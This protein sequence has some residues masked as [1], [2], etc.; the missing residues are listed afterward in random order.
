MA[1]ENSITEDYWNSISKK[2]KSDKKREYATIGLVVSDIHNGFTEM[3]CRG[4]M[5]QAAKDD[6]NL[7]VFPGRYL[8]REC[9]EFGES[10]Y[11]YQ[12]NSVYYYARKDNVDAL[13]IS[14]DSIGCFT[15]RERMKELMD[16]YEDIPVVLVASKMEGY[17]SI[18]YDNRQGI[19]DGLN[20]M[21]EKLG[22]KKICVM[23]G[24]ASNTD[25]TER[26]AVY[27]EVL[28]EHNIKVE[29]RQIVRGDMTHDCVS[30]FAKLLDDNPDMEGVFCINDEMALGLY[31]EMEKRHI[32]PG[33]DI[34][35]LGYD[36]IVD[37]A[38]VKPSLSSV[39]ADPRQLGVHAVKAV[40]KL[41]SGDRTLENEVMKT[42][43]ILRESFGSPAD[44]L[45]L[46][47]QEMCT[48]DAYNEAFDRIFY[49]YREDPPS[50]LDELH[51]HFAAFS[52]IIGR[53]LE[54]QDMADNLLPKLKTTIDSFFS[55]H[56]VRYA[57]TNQLI[58]FVN[59]MYNAAKKYYLENCNK[60]GMLD[61]IEHFQNRII[62]GMEK[63]LDTIHR[64][65]EK[66]NYSL[67]QFIRGILQFEKGGDLSYEGFLSNLTWMNI[68]HGRVFI[69]DKP[70]THLKGENFIP[71]ETMKLK[72]EAPDGT[73]E[74][75]PAYK[76]D[77]LI[78]KIFDYGYEPR[79][80]SIVVFPLYSSENLYGMVQYDL[81][82]DI[83]GEGDFLTSQMGSACK[84][85]QLLNEN[86]AIQTQLEDNLV[87]MREN[88]VVLD[89]LSKSDALTGIFNRRGFFDSVEKR[90]GCGRVDNNLIVAYVDMDNLKIINDRYGHEE[91][92][93]SLKLISTILSDTI[94]NQ[95]IV[96]RIGGDEFAFVI[97]Y[98][99]SDNGAGLVSAIKEKFDQF[100]DVSDKPYKVTVSVGTHYSR[101]GK[102]FD[103]E[104]ALERAD[105]MLYKEKK[106]RVK[107]VAKI[108]SR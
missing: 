36:N 104:K 64:I 91:G 52:D 24:P 93:F 98:D 17:L 23:A 102:K 88:N 2:N 55:L 58:Q 83:F 92:D 66:K 70:L 84:M 94:G 8:D 35:V 49:R 7:V 71:P 27:K 80:F 77:T 82:N 63:E 25:S 20:Y 41:L 34:Y 68:R 85:I 61:V 31:D 75:V 44:L 103:I 42:S 57:D 30:E 18:N 9:S 100:N 43:F 10:V 72:V 16:Y 26:L 45:D 4:A 73:A 38:R 90:I 5:S 60:F 1:A 22:V 89:N 46:T 3:V 95:G 78:S 101:K 74:V 108:L 12:Y 39:W 54:S 28:A 67:K 32:E 6:L 11:D 106:Q 14:A 81:S 50:E 51:F 48:P 15:T 47:L 105:V 69:F 87:A 13:I 97:E 76:Q 56:P 21:I 33:K 37:G 79:A 107:N 96:A 99:T 65:N 40:A 19:I 29:D 86:E 53:G 59:R 62:F